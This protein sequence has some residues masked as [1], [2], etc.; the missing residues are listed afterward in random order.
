MQAQCHVDHG[1]HATAALTPADHI[2]AQCHVDHGRHATAALTPADHMQAQCHVDYGHHA[3]GANPRRPQSRYPTKPA[4]RP[5]GGP[6]RRASAK[7]P[8]RLSR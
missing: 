5:R 3:D 1:R 8:L 4:R 2:Q 6:T 7:T